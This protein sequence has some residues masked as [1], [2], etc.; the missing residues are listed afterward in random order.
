MADASAEGDAGML[1]TTVACPHCAE[2][3]LVAVSLSAI[4]D[5][6]PLLKT[7]ERLT[8]M[9]TGARLLVN[10][11]RRQI[12]TKDLEIEALRATV[13]EVLVAPK[14]GGR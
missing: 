8:N 14:S 5:Q 6:Q 12:I 3:L 10:E 1:L 7:N 2:P 9:L 13:A 4:A 11:L